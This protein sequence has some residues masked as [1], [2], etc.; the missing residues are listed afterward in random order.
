V[1]NLIRAGVRETVAMSVSGHKT[2]SMLDRY[3]I[4]ATDDVKEAIEKVSVPRMPR[5]CHHMYARRRRSP[6]RGRR[7]HVRNR[8]RGEEGGLITPSLPATP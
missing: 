6:I 7:S 8:E 2:R 1:R 3:N 4:V 5:T